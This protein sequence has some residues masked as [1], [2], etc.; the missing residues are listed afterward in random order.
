MQVPLLTVVRR[1][2]SAARCPCPSHCGGSGTADLPDGCD[3]MLAGST[4][5]DCAAVSIRSVLVR[6]QGPA[7]ARFDPAPTGRVLS[8]SINGPGH[9]RLRAVHRPLY[10]RLCFRG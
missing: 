5:L 10:L 4:P 8:P 3:L 9:T 6:I 2:M 7:A 1:P